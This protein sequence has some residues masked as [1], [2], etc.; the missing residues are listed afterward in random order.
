MFAVMIRVIV[1][2]V[3]ET[4]LEGTHATY[5]TVSMS[6]LSAKKADVPNL[7][8]TYHRITVLFE[9]KIVGGWVS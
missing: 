1:R 2:R 7:A 3:L 8:T 9:K 6:D 5:P 4:M